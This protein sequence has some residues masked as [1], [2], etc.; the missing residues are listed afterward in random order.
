LGLGNDP[1][2][3]P[4]P[5]DGATPSSGRGLAATGGV[6]QAAAVSTKRPLPKKDA[7]KQFIR[8]HADKIVGI[9]SGFDRLIFRGYLREI[10][11]AKGLFMYLCWRKIRLTDSAGLPFDSARG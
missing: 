2:T 1:A 8:Q 11:F 7:M 3:R 4:L 9:L 10:S 5:L 6:L